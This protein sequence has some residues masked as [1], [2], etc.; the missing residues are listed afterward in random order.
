MNV[1]GKSSRGK[2]RQRWEK[3]I[4]DAFGTTAA[5]SRVAEDMHQ[6]HIWAATS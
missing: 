4:T 6:F 3:Y 2:P 1:A 5:A